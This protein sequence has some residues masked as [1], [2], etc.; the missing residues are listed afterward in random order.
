[1]SSYRQ[2]QSKA[3]TAEQEKEMKK[4]TSSFFWKKANRGQKQPEVNTTEKKKKFVPKAQ[5]Q[6]EY[7][8][9]ETRQAERETMICND[10]FCV[11]VLKEQH[12]LKD[13]PRCFTKNCPDNIDD[14]PHCY[15]DCTKCRNHHCPDNTEGKPHRHD[16]CT[17]CSDRRC[18]KVKA[19]HYFEHTPCSRCAKKHAEGIDCVRDVVCHWHKTDTH[20]TAA[21]RTVCHDREC[22][23]AEYLPR[24]H[25]TFAH[26]KFERAVVV[27]MS[28]VEADY[29]ESEAEYE[30][31]EAEY[32]DSEVDAEVESREAVLLREQQMVEQEMAQLRA[33]TQ[34]TV[35]VP[36]PS[37]QQVT[38]D[39]ETAA[40]V[41]A[42]QQNPAFFQ[43]MMQFQQTTLHQ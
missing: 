22:E 11:E 10:K 25:T 15:V 2:N 41:R 29:D 13:C 40:V 19:H 9:R 4:L 33:H 32:E 36:E 1:M 17:G 39:S 26:K 31:S 3:N 34:A 27:D 5:H 21:C 16:D 30:E 12:S 24:L 6:P 35:P 14:K 7:K 38:L 23:F 42:Y 28:E 8:D 43:A 20:S 18:T 37:V